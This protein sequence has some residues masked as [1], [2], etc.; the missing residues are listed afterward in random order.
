MEDVPDIEELVRRYSTSSA[1]EKSNIENNVIEAYTPLVHKIAN[2]YKNASR[3]GASDLQDRI[4]DGY[5][6]LLQ[7]IRTYD[8]NS[9][10][11]FLTYA[12]FCVRQ[13]VF[14]G[15]RDINTAANSKA[16]TYSKLQRYKKEKAELQNQLGRVPSVREISLKTGWRVKT[17][18]TY[19]R[20]M[21]DTL[22]LSNSETLDSAYPKE[23]E[24]Q[25]NI[26]SSH[27]IF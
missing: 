12:F 7:A 15:V 24:N 1:E 10:V 17:I 14:F 11:K 6:G 4:Q 26:C 2:K 21:C 25:K 18:L 23:W 5:Q 20:Y 8:P 13:S 16:Y 19:E 3:N 22:S 9:G 27:L